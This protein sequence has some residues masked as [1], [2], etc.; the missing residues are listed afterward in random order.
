VTRTSCWSA[1]AKLPMARRW[2]G[3]RSAEGSR[4]GV[5]RADGGRAAG[6]RGAEAGAAGPASREAR[7]SPLFFELTL[8]LSKSVS[9]FHASLGDNARLAREAGDADGEESWSG[10]VAEVDEMITQATNGHWDGCTSRC[11]ASCFLQPLSGSPARALCR[12]ATTRSRSRAATGPMQEISCNVGHKST[13]APRTVYR[14]DRP[15]DPRRRDGGGQR[16]RLHR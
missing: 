5:C 1:S 6:H 9:I 13:H 4:G 8:S 2:G 3:R 11:H 16:P 14:R 12:V 7:Q 15:C 10:S